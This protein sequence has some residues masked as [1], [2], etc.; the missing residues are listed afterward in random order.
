VLSKKVT[1]FLS[2]IKV[3]GL[4][5][6]SIVTCL[7]QGHTIISWQTDT[8]SFLLSWGWGLWIWD[9]TLISSILVATGRKKIKRHFLKWYRVFLLRIAGHLK[10]NYWTHTCTKNIRCVITQILLKL[11]KLQTSAHINCMN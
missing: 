10:I 4:E 6:S 11:L 2:I 8:M 7:W 9:P 3:A 5:K 1:G